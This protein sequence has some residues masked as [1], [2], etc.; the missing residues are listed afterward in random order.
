MLLF[1]DL[2]PPFQTQGSIR[3]RWR[4][5]PFCINDVIFVFTIVLSKDLLASAASSVSFE[6]TSATVVPD[7]Q[8]DSAMAQQRMQR[9]LRRHDDSPK[10]WQ[11][12]SVDHMEEFPVAAVG[13][14]EENAH[15]SDSRVFPGHA[16]EQSKSFKSTAG[17]RDLHPE[18][19]GGRHTGVQGSRSAPSSRE[20]SDSWRTAA[21]AISQEPLHRSQRRPA[22]AEVVGLSAA[23]GNVHDADEAWDTYL[24]GIKPVRPVGDLVDRRDISNHQNRHRDMEGSS[25][26]SAWKPDNTIRRQETSAAVAAPAV[27][28]AVAPAAGTVPAGATATEPAQI[29]A[30]VPAPAPVVAPAPLPAPAPAPAP[31]PVQPIASPPGPP[32]VGQPL[33]AAAKPPY[34]PGKVDSDGDGIADEDELPRNAVLFGMGLGV[35]LVC[36]CGG[37]LWMLLRRGSSSS[38]FR[39]PLQ[40]EIDPATGYRRRTTNLLG[41]PEDT[42]GNGI[43]RA[44]ERVADPT[45]R[46]SVKTN[47]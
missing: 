9:L 46:G 19:H 32:I 4:W 24:A 16:E 17:V 35:L 18:T 1:G 47:T 41:N 25:G 40:A 44:G 43:A 36:C 28:A 20:R 7:I 33:S 6:V 8:G 12:Q 38:T 23:A 26:R 30:A 42:D 22:S 21:S 39:Q 45:S 14:V 37:I 15:H 27:T 13:S 34:P 29:V 11:G 10:S 2:S 5:R 31:A 3:P